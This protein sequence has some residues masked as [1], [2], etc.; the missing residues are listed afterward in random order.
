M[1][2]EE[3][4]YR[5]KL[6]PAFHFTA[7]QGWLN[8]PNGCV[9]HDGEYHLFFQHNPTGVDWGNMTWGHAVSPDLVRWRQL[10]H[11]ILP[12]G[13][14]TIFS[15]SAVVDTHNTSGLGK[16]GKPPLVALFSHAR[17]PFGQAL[18]TSTDKG[19]SWSL[20]ANGDHVVPNQGLD[21]SERD[22]KVFWHSPSGKWIMVLWVQKGR[23]RFFSSPDLLHWTHTSD[24]IGEGF[25]ECPDL[26]ELPVEGD[27][28]NRK[29]ILHDA[30]F[31]YWI[32]SFDGTAFR[33]ELGPVRGEYGGNFYAAQTWNNAPSGV[34]QI[35][36]MNGGQYPGM[37]FNQQMSFP[38]EL[39]L[40]LS[41]TAPFLRR[42]P[43]KEI[44]SLHGQ[45]V[46]VR[47]LPVKEA[48]RL[49][50]G[51]PAGP[52]DIMVELDL[53]DATAVDIRISGIHICYT[54][55]DQ[56]LSCLGSKAPLALEEGIL[57]LRALVDI[58]SIELFGNDGRVSL[59]SCFLPAE[60]EPGLTL[61]ACGGAAQLGSLEMIALKSIWDR[62]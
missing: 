43:V 45:T 1:P 17:K 61:S 7:R 50:E 29:W 41:G 38:C 28:R 4:T 24:F 58:T 26:F 53:R 48:I 11:A 15:G 40:G 49:G 57:K 19:R 21:E 13:G 42:R 25:Y 34:V 55:G 10:D 62:A 32:G 46:R 23:A 12:Y 52:L 54:A 47:N 35:A 14:G 60:A 51:L 56:T 31:K 30:S 3:C 27:A 44:E 5:E 6:R 59:S 22:P 9:F 16:N 36:W 33:A 39:T 37:P 18:A 20:F 2:M 8:D